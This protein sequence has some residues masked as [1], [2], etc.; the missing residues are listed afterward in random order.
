M[1]RDGVPKTIWDNALE[2]EPYVRSHKALDVYMLQG[3]VPE[4]LMSSGTYDIRQFCEHGFYNLVIFRGEPIQY[5]DENPVLGR[6]L[7]PE[8]DVGLVMMD[9]FMKAKR[10]VASGG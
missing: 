5:P 8:I 10:E 4:T 2:F 3:E 7:G 9:K 1:I 6:Y